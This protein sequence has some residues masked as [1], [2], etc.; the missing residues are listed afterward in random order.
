MSS[1][2]GHQRQDES[3]GAQRAIVTW[4]ADLETEPSNIYIVSSCVRVLLT[5]T[6]LSLLRPPDFLHDH[7]GFLLSLQVL[8]LLFNSQPFPLYK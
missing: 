4:L 3:C 2:V 1:S 7:M 8:W 6:A 5:N